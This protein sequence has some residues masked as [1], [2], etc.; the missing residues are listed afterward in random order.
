MKHVTVADTLEMS[1]PERI[2]LVEEIW[3]SIVASGDAVEFTEAEKRLIDERL[4][5]HRGNPDA[6]YSWEDAYKLITEKGV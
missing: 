2:Q 6:G 1:I 5:S 4:A 3:D